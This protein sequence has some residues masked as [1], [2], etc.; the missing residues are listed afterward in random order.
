[1][2]GLRSK[3]WS[4]VKS[5]KRAGSGKFNLSFKSLDLFPP[6]EDLL[7]FLWK[8]DAHIGGGRA[9]AS[10]VAFGTTRCFGIM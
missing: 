1:M 3:R 9:W 8:V 7:L 10:L 6:L 2:Q 4:I 5:I